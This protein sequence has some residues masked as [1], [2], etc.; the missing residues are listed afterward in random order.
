MLLIQRALI[1]DTLVGPFIRGTLRGGGSLLGGLINRSM[2]KGLRGHQLASDNKLIRTTLNSKE[3][4]DS[5]GAG[6]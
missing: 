4:P 6:V 5:C 3:L 1:K 2:R